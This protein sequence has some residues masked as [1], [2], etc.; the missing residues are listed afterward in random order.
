[1]ILSLGHTVPHSYKCELQKF[2]DLSE[3][4]N[5]KLSDLRERM[6]E[7][8]K[9]IKALHE[10]SESRND[11]LMTQLQDIKERSNKEMEMLLEEIAVI[12]GEKRTCEEKLS[13][14]HQ[15]RRDLE[16]EA[17]RLG[18]EV[19]SLRKDLES[20]AMTEENGGDLVQLKNKLDV[21]SIS[22]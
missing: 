22:K 18:L 17:H 4:Q 7:E 20:A 3:S 19:E 14:S 9:K 8:R 1:M 13:E 21:L 16:K 5:I 10:E 6:D 11:A 15:L 2:K 12:K